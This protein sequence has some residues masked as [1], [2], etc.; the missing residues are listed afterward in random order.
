MEFAMVLSIVANFINL[1]A[2]C[3]CV[4]IFFLKGKNP[5]KRTFFL[6]FILSNVCIVALV[7]ET[8]ALALM[9]E[10]YWF[11]FIPMIIWT[12]CGAKMLARY[13]EAKK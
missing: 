6:G 3:T 8:I 2:A 10:N 13:N 11:N 4:C 12:Y 1:A 9:G 5:T 7:C